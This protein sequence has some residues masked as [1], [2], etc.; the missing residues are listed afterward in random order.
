MK[1]N[2]NDKT[3]SL[4]PVE[5]AIRYFDPYPH[6]VLRMMAE[7]YESRQRKKNR[8]DGEG[9]SNIEKT[10]KEDYSLSIPEMINAYLYGNIMEGVQVGGAVLPLREVE[11]IGQHKH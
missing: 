7:D 10:S 6:P 8:F 1:M 5:E 2:R 3:H 11:V 9:D 4:T